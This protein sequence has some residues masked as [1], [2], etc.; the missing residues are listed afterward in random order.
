MKHP[1]TTLVRFAVL[2][3]CVDDVI[4]ELGRKGLLQFVDFSL[5]REHGD[6][7]EPCSPAETLYTYSSLAARIGNIISSLRIPPPKTAMP[8]PPEG[9]ISKELLEKADELCRKLEGLRASLI[10]KEEEIRRLKEAKELEEL[11]RLRRMGVRKTVEELKGRLGAEA[12]V[13]LKELKQRLKKLEAERREVESKINEAV[14]TYG[15]ELYAYWEML[16]NAAVFEEMKGMGG[17]AGGLRV[18]EAWTLRKKVPEVKEAVSRASKGFYLFE[19]VK[20]QP[21]EEAEAPTVIRPPRLLSNYQSLVNAF[22]TPTSYEVNPALMMSITFPVFFGLMFGDVGHGLLL[23]IGA[24]YFTYLKRKGAK[25][26]ELLE[27]VAQ[28]SQLLLHCAIAA[29]IVGALF[30]G[31]FFGSHK[32]Y[33]L[34]FGLEGPPFPLASLHKPIPML[35]LS[36]FIGIFHII[37]GLLLDLIIKVKNGEVKHALVGPFTWLILYSTVG[38]LFIYYC[39][40]VRASRF[41]SDLFVFDVSKLPIPAPPLA[42]ILGLFVLMMI[43]RVKFEGLLEGFGSSL[44]AF[45][46]T[47]SHTISY[48]RIFAFFLVHH[49]ISEIGLLGG[50]E[51]GVTVMGLFTFVLANFLIMSI[52]LLATFLQ[53]LRLHWVEWFLKFYEGAGKPFTP[54]SFSMSFTKVMQ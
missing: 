16:Q 41:I 10:A 39:F 43:V 33:Q 20:L 4:R 36:I 17:K 49:A 12:E 24:L 21:Y 52:E 9:R 47:I 40:A 45:V 34:I 26:H 30:Y 35:K 27:P 53:A 44:E 13:E 23:L 38:G 6:I 37:S 3:E 8:A 42:L 22:G 48:T 11:R 54:M 25:V 7:I 46:A 14:K 31:T 29:T 32:W 2:E 5:R 50:I 1:P 18:F 15:S 51:E 28:G 19:E